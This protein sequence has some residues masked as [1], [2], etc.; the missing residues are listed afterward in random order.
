MLV[1]SKGFDLEGSVV[2]VIADQGLGDE[3]FFLRFVPA[4]R[5]RG[6]TVHYRPD[7]RLSDML[8]RAHAVDNIVAP[9]APIRGDF[10]VAVGDLPWLLGMG[11]SLGIFHVF[12]NLNVFINGVAVA[13]VQQAAMPAIVTVAAWSF[14]SERILITTREPSVTEI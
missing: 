9:T 3:I 6:A 4:L 10:V 12:W 11:A 7:P 1:E 2:T 8:E 13:T 5:A 14:L